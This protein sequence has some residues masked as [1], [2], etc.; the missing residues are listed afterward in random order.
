MTPP[1][2]CSSFPTSLALL[3]SRAPRALRPPPPWLAKTLTIATAAARLGIRLVTSVGTVGYEAALHAA[4]KAGGEVDIILQKASHEQLLDDI[5]S[6]FEQ[7]SIS[8]S[9]LPGRATPTMRDEAVAASAEALVGVH[10][11]RRGTMARV[12]REAFERTGIRVAIWPDGPEESG[13]GSVP[14]PHLE[15]TDW[16]RRLVDSA[17]E[18][19]DCPL[20]SADWFAGRVSEAPGTL[21]ICRWSASPLTGAL[22]SHFT[23]AQPGPWPGQ[24]RAHWLEDLRHGGARMDRSAPAALARILR[25]GRIRAGSR[26]IRGGW[27]VVSLTGVHPERIARLH[28]YQTHLMRWD[29]E[30]F[31]LVFRR[32]ILK[33]LGARPVIHAPS[34]AYMRLPPSLRPFFQKCEPPRCDYRAEEE[35]RIPGDLDLTQLP[36]ESWRVFP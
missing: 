11:R 35:W 4:L 36:R 31:G 18:E 28:R 24:S 14:V 19:G 32:D 10:I 1:V 33:D 13:Q 26:L 6:V 21:A 12:L 8:I 20:W 5:V 2:P 34:A 17:K 7:P 16:G 22:L 23:R 9:I 25:E 30:P 29:F 27:P 3:N 15:Q